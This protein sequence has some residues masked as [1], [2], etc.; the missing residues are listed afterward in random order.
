MTT[1][2]TSPAIVIHLARPSAHHPI[3]PIRRQTEDRSTPV[4]H[5]SLCEKHRTPTNTPPPRHTDD[6]R[7]REEGVGGGGEEGSPAAPPTTRWVRYGVVGKLVSVWGNKFL[8]FSSE[9]VGS[10]MWECLGTLGRVGMCRHVLRKRAVVVSSGV[11]VK[12]R[13]PANSPQLC[14]QPEACW[15]RGK[16]V[17]SCCLQA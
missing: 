3:T 8:P 5:R 11:V 9:G 13:L 14:I 2:T 15:G 10:F 12:C 16:G 4:T 7:D 17:H 6:Q 1:T